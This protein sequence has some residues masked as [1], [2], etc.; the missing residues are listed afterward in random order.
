MS[1]LAFSVTLLGFGLGT[2]VGLFFLLKKWT[3]S[4]AL[5]TISKVLVG[6][7]LALLA[8]IFFISSAYEFGDYWDRERPKLET[9]LEGAEVG[10]SKSEVYFRKGK[11]LE[12]SVYKDGTFADEAL[13]Y[14]DGQVVFIKGDKVSKI[15]IFC[16]SDTDYRNINW[17][18]CGDTFEEI[19][20]KYGDSNNVSESKDDL[21]RI[22]NYPQYGVAF[23]LEAGRVSTLW[24]FEPKDAPKGIRFSE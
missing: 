21:R 24:V 10:W 14:K 15:A 23:V 6:G 3:T 7:V 4:S 8:V 22:Y 17:L 19:L 2:S 12:V 11:P 18:G 1:Y 9:K 20:D 13:R 5:G 16:G